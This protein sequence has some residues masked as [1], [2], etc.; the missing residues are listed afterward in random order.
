[1]LAVGILSG[2]AE[3]APP[4]KRRARPDFV[5]EAVD[6]SPPLNA[7]IEISPRAKAKLAKIAEEVAPGEPW[8]VRFTIAAGGCSGM[9]ENLA[10]DTMPLGLDDVTHDCGEVQIV[11]A[12]DQFPLVQGAAIDWAEDGKI[13]GFVISKGKQT[14]ENK[15]KTAKWVREQLERLA[16]VNQSP[17][18]PLAERIREFQ[19]SVS[20]D[21]VNELAHFRLGNLLMEDGRYRD[22]VNSFNRTIMLAPESSRAH[23]LLAECHIKLD[24]KDRAIEVLTKGLALAEKRGDAIPREAMTELLAELR[25]KMN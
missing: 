5:R 23:Q 10:L 13:A 14:Q 16:K 1:M 25:K 4:E 11:F 18:A 19:K 21:P 7:E 20:E 6:P 12:R 24:Q 2:C 22:A 17:T 9:K 3:S 8:R 15:E